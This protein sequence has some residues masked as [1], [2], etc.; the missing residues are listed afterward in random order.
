MG[1]DQRS[2]A[3]NCKPI[4]LFPTSILCYHLP[5]PSISP[6]TI[7]RY[8]SH[9]I[10]LSYY[11]RRLRS[12][13]TLINCASCHHR[14][15]QCSLFS[16]FSLYPFISHGTIRRYDIQGT[17][18]VGNHPILCRLGPSPPCYQLD[19]SLTWATSPTPI[20]HLKQPISFGKTHRYGIMETRAA[21]YTLRLII[22]VYKLLFSVA[23]PSFFFSN[24]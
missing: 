13:S 1:I 18:L 16:S 24:R 20:F 22:P 19:L 15:L 5:F 7:R 12:I 4:P 14:S 10:C 6:G 11:H 2:I 9:G 17:F 8:G 3:S 21:I 23:L